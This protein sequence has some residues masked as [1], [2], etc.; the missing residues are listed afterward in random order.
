MAA[1]ETSIGGF[2]NQFSTWRWTF[3]MLLIWAGA[4]LVSL[5]LFVP[6]TYHPVYVCQT[7]HWI[8]S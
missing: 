7:E 3:Y 4:V 8:S 2:I 1:D 6:E 5:I